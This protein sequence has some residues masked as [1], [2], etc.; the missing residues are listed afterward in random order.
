MSLLSLMDAKVVTRVFSLSDPPMAW[1]RHTTPRC[2][3]NLAGGRVEGCV[4]GGDVVGGVIGSGGGVGDNDG[5][6]WCCCW[7]E[8]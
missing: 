1:I 7:W 5:W 8:W 3:S 2:S 6:W 4:G